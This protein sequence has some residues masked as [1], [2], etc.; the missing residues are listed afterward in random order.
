LSFARLI[1]P[2]VTTISILRSSNKI[3]NGNI[4]VPV[5][6]PGKITVKINREREREER[7]CPSHCQSSEEK[8][9]P[10]TLKSYTY[11][12]SIALMITTG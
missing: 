11:W 12:R 6:P 9:E 1:A 3:Q 7:E 10:K 8:N 5:N 2:A 4:L